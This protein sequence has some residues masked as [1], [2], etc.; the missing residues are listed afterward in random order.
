M[1]DFS[2]FLRN[3]QSR[4]CGCSR[5]CM[6]RCPGSL[7]DCRQR[8][9]GSLIDCRQRCPGSLIQP[10]SRSF[11]PDD[12]RFSQQKMQYLF[13]CAISCSFFS[14]WRACTRSIMVNFLF[15]N[16]F[17]LPRGTSAALQACF[18]EQQR[19]FEELQRYF[20]EISSGFRRLTHA[21]DRS[22]KAPDEDK[23]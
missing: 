11:L 12:F 15:L 2:P 3:R 9:P 4:V 19:R 5:S 6:A 18:G 7:I 21:S 22:E 10:R 23:N 16:H 13:F 17:F 1:S 14:P 8:C 20:R